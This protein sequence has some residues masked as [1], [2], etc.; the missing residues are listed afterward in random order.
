MAAVKNPFISA[1]IP[2]FN[3]KL[4]IE[5]CVESLKNQTLDKSMYEIIVVDNGSSDN[6]Y[7][8]AK[9]MGAVVTKEPK[10]GVSGAR[11]KGASIA[12]GDIFV[13][14]DADCLYPE[15]WLTR[16]AEKFR[17]DPRL[18]A[19]GGTFVFYDANYF[20]KKVSEISKSFIYHIAGGNMAVRK[21]AFWQVG[22]FDTRYNIGEELLLQLKLKDLKKKIKIERSLVIYYSFRRFKK[23]F[24]RLSLFWM[25]NDFC[26]LLFRKPLNN[27]YSTKTPK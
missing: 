13:F 17:A 23:S 24:I 15:D 7:E 1:I 11:N 10:R 27:F 14:P 12:K 19:L 5:Q 22:G 21:E 6:T 20:W 18:D 4:Y 26:V 2:A 9:K 3:E 8:L 16:I 25:I